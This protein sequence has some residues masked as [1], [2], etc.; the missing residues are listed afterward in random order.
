MKLV[1][2]IIEPLNNFWVEDY[3]E[4]EKEFFLGLG[5]KEEISNIAPEFGGGNYL[6][7]VGSKMFGMWTDEEIDKIVIALNTAVEN[8]KIEWNGSVYQ[9]VER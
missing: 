2:K 3:N 1:T 8:G 7:Y 9:Y 6:N 5:F 4:N